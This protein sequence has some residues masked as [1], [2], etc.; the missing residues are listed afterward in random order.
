[1]LQVE[2]LIPEPLKSS[3]QRSAALH[4]FCMAIPYGIILV[5]AGAVSLFCGSGW[6]G[7]RTLLAGCFTLGLAN[8]S[9]QNWKAGQKTIFIGLLEAGVPPP[10]PNTHRACI[11][12]ISNQTSTLV[13]R[14]IIAQVISSSS[15]TMFN[16][17]E[18]WNLD[19]T[20]DR[21]VQKL[22]V[23]AHVSLP[24]FP[25][26]VMVAQ[27]ASNIPVPCSEDVDE[28]CEHASPCICQS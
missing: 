11:S 10:P 5:L 8:A 13:F 25:V 24:D 27:R 6:S 4:D 14:D 16:I 23:F 1:M 26:L 17:G 20:L 2:D 3:P 18:T 28:I 7:A 9:L 19:L 22:P 15:C 21:W 12:I